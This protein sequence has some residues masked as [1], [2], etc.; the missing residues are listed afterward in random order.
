MLVYA[1][2]DYNR[3]VVLSTKIIF[4]RQLKR[5][6]ATITDLTDRFLRNR[7]INL[8]VFAHLCLRV[9]IVL[10]RLSTVQVRSC[11]R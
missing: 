7:N 6:Q 9:I 11:I 5:K 1:L 8:L 3:K 2:S 10:K 4:S